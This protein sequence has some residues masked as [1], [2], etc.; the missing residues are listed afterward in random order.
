L[1]L[2]LGAADDECVSSHRVN[3]TPERAHASPLSNEEGFPPGPLGPAPAAP[4][5]KAYL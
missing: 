4:S 3:P 1:V 2:G 5:E